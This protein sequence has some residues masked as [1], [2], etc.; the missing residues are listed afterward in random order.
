MGFQ[1]NVFIVK[2]T[3]PLY[4]LPIN[5]LILFA[6]LSKLTINFMRQKMFEYD[7]LKLEFEKIRKN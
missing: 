2:D 7:Q 1:S 3:S 5:D 6:Y 4:V